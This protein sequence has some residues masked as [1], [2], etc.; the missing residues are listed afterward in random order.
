MFS[1]DG[2]HLHS[3]GHRLLSY[4]AA[5]VLGIPDAE[6][7]GGLDD[8][9]HTGDE[10]EGGPWITEHALPWVWRRMR[11]RTAGD[12]IAAKHDDWVVIPGRGGD[13]RR[14]EDPSGV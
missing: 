11:G 13:R 14:A 8:A 7:L 12:G 4:R 5:E 1:A 9:L 2:V 10:P 3:R 6:A